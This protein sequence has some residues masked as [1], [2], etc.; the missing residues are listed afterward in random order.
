MGEY[1]KILLTKPL[2]LDIH[3]IF[4][5]FPDINKF[6]V[7]IFVHTVQ[8]LR[9]HGITIWDWN[10]IALVYGM[11]NDDLFLM[12]I[13]IIKVT[14]RSICSVPGM[15]LRALHP[16]PARLESLI[17]LFCRKGNGSSKGAR[18]LP[19]VTQCIWGRDRIQTSVWRL[20]RTSSRL[21]IKLSLDDYL[22]PLFLDFSLKSIPFQ[23]EVEIMKQ[24][25]RS[26]YGRFF[27]L[28]YMHISL[29]SMLQT[30][31]F[32]NGMGFPFPGIC[33][34]FAWTNRMR[35]MGPSSSSNLKSQEALQ[36]LSSP[37]NL[38][39]SCK[40]AQVS[41]PEPWEILDSVAPCPQGCQP[42]EPSW[43]AGNQRWRNPA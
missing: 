40:Q 17:S 29:Q 31:L 20:P 3:A 42:T 12:L 37:K 43:L 23:V 16:S 19:K 7:N 25:Q 34:W 2:L 1:S 39:L 14:T 22:G 6:A 9:S 4:K 35:R 41:L 8:A 27:S 33:L 38:S 30:F 11:W 36:L 28:A 24:Q 5:L 21:G 13:V 32:E 26:P 15:V 18:D 10:S